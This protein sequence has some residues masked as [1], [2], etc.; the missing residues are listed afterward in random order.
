MLV[1]K[2]IATDS[3]LGALTASELTLVALVVCLLAA[4][5][6]QR[7]KLHPLQIE[8]FSRPARWLTYNAVAFVILMFGTFAYT[9]FIYFQF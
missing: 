5:W 4:E 6:L 7:R 3:H 1:F 8:H 2:A 9:P